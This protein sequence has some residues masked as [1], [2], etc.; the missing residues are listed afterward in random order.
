MGDAQGQRRLGMM[1]IRHECGG[2]G[3]DI[4]SARGD[5]ARHAGLVAD[6]ARIAPHVRE[7]HHYAAQEIRRWRRG[8]AHRANEGIKDSI[9]RLETAPA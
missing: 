7:V 5:R 8:I 4:S 2:R 3:A 6:R 9:A 1:S